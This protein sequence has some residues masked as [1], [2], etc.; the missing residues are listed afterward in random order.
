MT[1]VA[2]V[3]EARTAVPLV[4]AFGDT[5]SDAPPKCRLAD[6]A[7]NNEAAVKTVVAV[8][9]IVA[10]VLA[11]AFNA[12][13]VESGVVLD[14]V[15]PN[16]VGAPN[17]HAKERDKIV[18]AMVIRGHYSDLVDLDFDRAICDA[19]ETIADTVCRGLQKYNKHCHRQRTKVDQGQTE[20]DLGHPGWQGR[21]EYWLHA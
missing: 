4:L 16:E 20:D 14:M 6:L 2:D 11:I 21:P 19:V 12:C 10:E 1:L 18:I 13:L 5:N 17:A 3:K 9:T 15:V 8:E 7:G